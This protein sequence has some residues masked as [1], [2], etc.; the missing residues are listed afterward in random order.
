M[1]QPVGGTQTMKERYKR[2]SR[3]FDGTF[4]E[5]INLYIPLG[6]IEILQSQHHVTLFRCRKRSSANRSLKFRFTGRTYP[7]SLIHGSQR[8]HSCLQ[9]PVQNK[10]RWRVT[11]LTWCDC[12]ADCS[13]H[14][15]LCVSTSV[16]GWATLS[17]LLIPAVSRVFIRE[18]VSCEDQRA[19]CLGKLWKS[20]RDLYFQKPVWA[21]H[22]DL[23]EG[24][25]IHPLCKPW[26]SRW[27]PLTAYHPR[28]GGL[29]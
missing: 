19:P 4:V 2:L 20:E 23:L 28:R 25:A 24:Y 22:T 3:I 6:F 18:Q 5:Q 27:L 17:K 11:A 16:A 12:S 26:T 10:K 15:S 9:G 1:P 8:I 21:A 14:H 29:K 7:Q 13:K